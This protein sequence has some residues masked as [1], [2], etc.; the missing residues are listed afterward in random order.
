MG[1]CV[2][3]FVGGRKKGRFLRSNKLSPSDKRNDEK[4]NNTKRNFLK[5]LTST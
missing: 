4:K 5:I 1:T 2:W 3:H